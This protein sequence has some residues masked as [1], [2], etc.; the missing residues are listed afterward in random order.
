MS[1]HF[2]HCPKHRK[3]LPCAHCALIMT[4]PPHNA[5]AKT[6]RP[7]DIPEDIK[8]KIAESLAAAPT[9]VSDR[10]EAIDDIELVDDVA[11]KIVRG[12]RG[13]GPGA[14]KS[15]VQKSNALIKHDLPKKQPT[16]LKSVAHHVVP[17]TNPD[18]PFGYDDSDRPI[19]VPVGKHY[20]KPVQTGTVDT[21]TGPCKCNQILCRHCHP[22]NNVQTAT[23]KGRHNG[24][25]LEIVVNV[26]SEPE[27]ALRR[28]CGE[29]I[30]NSTLILKPSKHH[31]EFVD[32][33]KMFQLTRTD[34]VE[35]LDAQVD[36]ERV[37]DV[38]DTTQ[39][40]QKILKSSGNLKQDINAMEN[41]ID[42]AEKRIADI[43]DQI[44][45]SENLIDV[46]W[47][48]HYQKI[49]VKRGVRQ[50]D[51]IW[52]TATREKYKREERQKITQLEEDRSDLR[53]QLK[54]DKQRLVELQE[55]IDT[56]GL[57]DED[58]DEQYPRVTREY[59]IYFRDKFVVPEFKGQP[60][61]GYR[62]VATEDDNF[63]GYLPS[64][65][66]YGTDAYVQAVHIYEADLGAVDSIFKGWRRFENE[67]VLQAIGWGLVQPSHALLKKHPTLTT[68][69][70][71][72]A[73]NAD[74]EVESDDSDDDAENAL[75]FKTGGAQIGGAVYS[76][77]TRWN[78]NQRSLSSFD[79]PVGRKQYDKD[80]GGES[81]H[82]D[83]NIDD[84]G[85]Y[86]PD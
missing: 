64:G 11:E 1:G 71:T 70:D 40:K 49:E 66:E 60:P 20:V 9:V 86:Q 19:G 56:W 37:E 81:D 51:D 82:T 31:Y 38:L 77:G 41:K 24:G 34:L 68:Y 17:S 62:F 76:A 50:P 45:E 53:K 21:P 47:S 25:R 72:T 30:P 43:G 46:I 73:M 23:L 44:K 29:Q 33:V 85:S 75:I 13:R 32:Y 2:R 48:S 63:K 5:D 6:V 54:T 15:T 22:E 39:P 28:L 18:A 26:I 65:Y 16:Y 84:S 27:A 35:L 36:T 10:V 8:K 78:G 7:F 42:D 12:S 80:G 55:H 14:K 57:R 59:P 79:G 52:D 83:D 4:I 67:L 58:Y 74:P 69:I 61:T 3:P